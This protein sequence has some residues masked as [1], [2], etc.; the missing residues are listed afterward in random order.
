MGAMLNKINAKMCPGG[1]NKIIG[2]MI[3]KKATTGAPSGA[4]WAFPVGTFCYNTYDGDGYICT[5]ATGTWV[6]INA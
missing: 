1:Q 4:S 6:K 3:V 5:V 2:R